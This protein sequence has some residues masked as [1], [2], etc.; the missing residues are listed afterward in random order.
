MRL[1]AGSNLNHTFDTGMLLRTIS[2]YNVTVQ[3][4][5]GLCIPTVTSVLYLV[6]REHKAATTGYG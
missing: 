1:S 4:L 2:I 3:P 5:Q 6:F